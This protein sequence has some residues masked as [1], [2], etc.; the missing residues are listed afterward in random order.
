M[1]LLTPA[2]DDHICSFLTETAHSNIRYMQERQK[3][4]IEYEQQNAKNQKLQSNPTIDCRYNWYPLS[5]YGMFN[6]SNRP[7]AT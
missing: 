7:M 2:D 5:N 6:I 3:V 4:I 1:L